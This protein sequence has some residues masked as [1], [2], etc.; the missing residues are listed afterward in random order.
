[1]YRGRRIVTALFATAALALAAC[2][3]G[4]DAADTT[5]PAD[6]ASAETAAPETAAPET[7]APA[8]TVGTTDPPDTVDPTD[9]SAPE[10]TDAPTVEPPVVP[11][12]VTLRVGDQSSTLERPLRTSGQLDEVQS[13]LEFATF[14]GG[15]P[16]VEAFNADALDVGYVGDTPPILAQARGQ[17][18]VIV[19][20]WRFNGNVMALVSPPGKG[21]TSLEDLRGK[22]VAYSTGTA[23]QAFAIRALAEGGLSESDV[24]RVDVPIL[25]IV[26]TLKSGD[27]DAG[28]LVEPILASYLAETPDATIVRDAEGLTTGLQF[29]I[30]TSEVLADPDLSAALG[31]FV[32]RQ[33]L[34]FAWAADNPEATAEAF[35]EDNQISIEQATLLIER[36]GSQLFVP[37]DE[38]VIDP[39]QAL[40]DTFS[41]AGAIPEPIDVSLIVDDRFN[42]LIELANAG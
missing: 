11:D 9:T 6:T 2:G 38:E 42:D 23:L 22:N 24:N 28:V 1:M 32:Y 18:L 8:D 21:I 27:V 19:G 41:E 34:A 7:A 13:E 5:S 16:L 12:G 17:D 26:G 36:N 33:A 10:A 40:A 39:L 37:L 31:D 3:S 4:D 14:V 30:T 15:P 25:D 35:A 20:A 29:I